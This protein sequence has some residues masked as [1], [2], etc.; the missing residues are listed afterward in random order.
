MI[1]RWTNCIF[2]VDLEHQSDR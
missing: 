2:A 1:D